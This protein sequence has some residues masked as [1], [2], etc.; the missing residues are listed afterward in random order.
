MINRLKRDKSMRPLSWGG[1]LSAK[2]LKLGFSY[3]RQQGFIRFSR[4]VPAGDHL[5]DRWARAKEMGF[6]EG[7]SIY[8]SA[9]VI[10]DVVVGD[11]TWIGPFV[12]LDG[13]GGLKI[14]NNCS[15]SAGVQIYTHDSVAWAISGG[16]RDVARAPVEIGDACYLG[17]NVIVQKGVVIGNGSIV[18]ANSFVRVS[19]PPGSFVAGNPAKVLGQ[20]AKWSGENPMNDK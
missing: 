1:W 16:V 4:H 15:I 12:V 5:I 11:E 6:G 9:L 10:G 3:L 2:W 19:V 13:S 14:G 7:T 20:A 8:D 17:P 18:G